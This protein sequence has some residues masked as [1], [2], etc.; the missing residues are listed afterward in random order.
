MCQSPRKKASNIAHQQAFFNGSSVGSRAVPGAIFRPAP[1]AI[2]DMPPNWSQVD[3]GVL[4]GP[5]WERGLNQKAVNWTL[6]PG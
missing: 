2:C 5:A 1:A 4:A 3:T 6:L